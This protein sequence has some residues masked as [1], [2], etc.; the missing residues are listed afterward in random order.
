MTSRQVANLTVF[1]LMSSLL[2]VVLSLARI[3]TIYTPSWYIDGNL[4]VCML[5]GLSGVSTFSSLIPGICASIL[6]G[7]LT[8]GLPVLILALYSTLFG[9]LTYRYY[10]QANPLLPLNVYKGV[11]WGSVCYSICITVY[12]AAPVVMAIAN[13]IVALL[14]TKVVVNKLRSIGLINHEDPELIAKVERDYLQSAYDRVNKLCS[15]SFSRPK[16]PIKQEGQ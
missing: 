3:M 1:T 4:A 16:R 7:Y 2:I 6:W 8:G 9:M 11:A 15:T 12:M 5:I 10:L 14:F 13:T